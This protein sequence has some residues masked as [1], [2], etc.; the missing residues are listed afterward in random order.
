MDMSPEELER[1]ERYIQNDMTPEESIQFESQASNNQILKDK[2]NEVRL[3][4]LGVQEASL[5]AKL[6]DFH[7]NLDAQN[8][9]SQTNKIFPF[10]KWLLAAAMIAVIAIGF[11]LLIDSF[12]ANENLY[13]KY[14]KA[15]P[16]LLSAMSFSDNY[17]FDR[18]MI[19]YKTANYDSALKNWE[20]LLIAN[21]KNDTLHYFIGA[22][23]L[24]LDKNEKAIQNFEEVLKIQTSYFF[25]DANWYKGLALIKEGKKA[26]A[27]PFIEKSAHANKASLLDEL[28]K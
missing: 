14:Y 18:A 11:W 17:Q 2:I 23:Y 9:D 27:I 25:S 5:T 12:N 7:T 4:L 22:S 3:L 15:D 1:I 28:K 13:S 8:G 10:K 6:E 20:T 19:E 26:E 24:A 16:G 21:P